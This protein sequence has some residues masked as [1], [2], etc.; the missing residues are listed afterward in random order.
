ML[1]FELTKKH[2]GIRLWGD[3]WTLHRIHDVLHKVNEQSSVIHDKEGF[4]LGLAY[5][6]RKAYEGQRETAIREFFED[7]CPIYGVDILW[8]VLIAQVGL[9]REAMGFIPTNRNDQIVAFELEY[10]IESAAE[11]VFPGR[12]EDIMNLMTRVG[13]CQSHIDEVLDSRCRFFIDLPP[14]K[15]LKMLPAVLESFDPMFKFISQMRVRSPRPDQI[16]PEDFVKY[17]DESNDWPDF[18]W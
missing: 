4:F 13:G 18:Q 3:T 14:A 15:R 5:D 1:Q 7:K 8:P 12:A 16:S 9:L 11:K 2:A 17:Q 6:I 10:L